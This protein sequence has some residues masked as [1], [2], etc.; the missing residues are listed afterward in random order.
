MFA[1]DSHRD[2]ITTAL[3]LLSG[4]LQ[5]IRTLESKEIVDKM[6][7]WSAGCIPHER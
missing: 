3:G 7:P 2:S 5:D 1:C 4:E 6:M